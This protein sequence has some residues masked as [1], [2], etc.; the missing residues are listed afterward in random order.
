M[1]FG[2]GTSVREDLEIPDVTPGTS[3]PAKDLAASCGS[4]Q[5]FSRSSLAVPLIRFLSLR[6]RPRAAIAPRAG[7]GPGT[8][9][10]GAD[11]GPLKL[12]I[13][14]EARPPAESTDCYLNPKTSPCTTE[15]VDEPD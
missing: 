12:L 11:V 2:A 6:L 4:A 5:Q 1:S 10:G 9:D 3:G 14:V 13:V 7:S 15:K 8:E